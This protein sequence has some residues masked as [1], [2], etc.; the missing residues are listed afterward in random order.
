MPKNPLSILEAYA[1]ARLDGA[2][3]VN[4]RPAVGQPTPGT[5]PGLRKKL[6]SR[7]NMRADDWASLMT[8]IGVLGTDKRLGGSWGYSSIDQATCQD[9]WRGDD[10]LDRIVTLPA[11]E[12]I[13]E[14]WEI[15]I[16]D[17]KATSD[18]IGKAFA[19]LRCDPG[20][21]WA[22]DKIYTGLTWARGYGGCGLLLGAD[23]GIRTT[24]DLA[25]PLNYD[26]IRSFEWMTPFTPMELVPVKWYCDPLQPRFGE[27]SQYRLTPLERPPGWAPD[28]AWLPIIHELR[29]ARFDGEVVSR[30]QML[31]NIHPGW[32][33]SVFVR[34]QQIVADFQAAWAGAGILLSDFSVPTLKV[35]GLADMLASEDPSN[36]SLSTRAEAIEQARSIAR[37]II[38][39]IDEEYERKTTSITGLPELL[40][41]LTNR[42]AAAARMP[43]S[44]LMGQAP[45]GLSATGDSDIR[46]FYDQV[47]ALQERKLRGPLTR[48][49]R[50]I[51]LA[52]NG[53]TNGK[54]PDDWALHFNPLW[55]LTDEQT[56][57]MRLQVAQADGIYLEN[58]VLTPEEVA[59]SRFGGV[60][61]S[62]D[63]KI[64]GELRNQ[65]LAD[66]ERQ[67]DVLAPPKPDPIEAEPPQAEGGAKPKAEG[68]KKPVAGGDDTQA[69]KDESGAV[70]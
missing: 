7:N 23:D 19:D 16:D 18:A 45:A 2:R 24:A 20:G 65:L 1:Q 60:K 58:G 25:L 67:T 62:I 61:Y 50:M 56:A 46:W 36:T 51:M 64:N 42:L 22:D 31:Y 34:I 6:A 30:G 32:G 54:E 3:E 39:D 17:D 21:A 8:G 48:I 29:I 26:N 4:P 66:T 11:S 27:V 44:L 35:K 63:T 5:S 12:M 68:G 69:D 33:D 38:I 57:T 40:Q 70:K 49:H 15:L 41:Q 28:L 55:Q 9:M 53:P 52:K 37:T 47:A 10:F 59:N 13:R 43:V 14:G